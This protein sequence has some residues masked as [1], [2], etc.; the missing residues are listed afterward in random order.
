MEDAMS[1]DPYFPFRAGDK[2]V[3]DGPWSYDGSG[4]VIEKDGNTLELTIDLPE[5]K[6]PFFMKIPAMHIRL[7]IEAEKEGSGNR[8]QAKINDEV[9]DDANVTIN[10]IQHAGRRMIDFS[11][12]V[13]GQHLGMLLQKTANNRASLAVLEHSFTIKPA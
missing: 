10:S 4:E 3:I 8:A 9:T 11:V 6:I 1:W 7:K 13:Q 12:P 2:L 5:Y